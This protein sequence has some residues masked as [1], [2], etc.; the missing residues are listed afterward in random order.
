MHLLQHIARV[1]DVA[2]VITNQVYT[3]VDGNSYCL[4]DSDRPMGGN[5]MTH[6]STFIIR[7]KGNS[8]YLMAEMKGSPC[9]PETV[10]C[11]GINEGGVWDIS[12]SH[13]D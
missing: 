2:V 6:T 4:A 10:K 8:S 9:Y 11:F 3:S 5:V 7:L 13:M 12:H 1:Y